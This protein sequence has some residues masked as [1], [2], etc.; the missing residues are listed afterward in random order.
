[1]KLRDVLILISVLFLIFLMSI[2][3]RDSKKEGSNLISNNSAETSTDSV[4]VDSYSNSPSYIPGLTA[5]DV[6]GNFKNIGF[7]IDKNFSGDIYEWICTLDDNGVS[8]RVTILGDSPY[9][10]LSVTGIAILSN[11]D[12]SISV[13][14]DFFKY[15]CSIPYDNNNSS[16]VQ[17]WLL[18]NF[19]GSSSTSVS[20]VEFSIHSPSSVS[21][22][23][24][25]KV[26]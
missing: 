1:M 3:I 17:N 19:N 6:H 24:T 7:R 8:Y 15:L 23:L 9:K 16:L 14:K 26:D 20:G 21:K 13:S 10:I 22:M 2:A 4:I 11:T 18:S 5:V 12:L 25:V